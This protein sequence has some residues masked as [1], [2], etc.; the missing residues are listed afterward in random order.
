MLSLSLTAGHRWTATAIR[1]RRTVAPDV[2][3][4]DD[5]QILYRDRPA[6]HTG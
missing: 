1:A 6:D 4:L 3:V 2:I 5:G